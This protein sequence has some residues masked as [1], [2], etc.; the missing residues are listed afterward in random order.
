MELNRLEKDVVSGILK[1]AD[2]EDIEEL[3]NRAGFD[4]Y[5][6][7]SLIMKATW[8]SVN[9]YIEEKKQFTSN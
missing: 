1:R 5:L 7:H 4:E 2:G 6:L 9:Y 3:V 8:E